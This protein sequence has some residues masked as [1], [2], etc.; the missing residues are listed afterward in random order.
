MSAANGFIATTDH[1]FPRN[2]GE[3]WLDFRTSEADLARLLRR[4]PCS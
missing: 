2:L 3:V 1:R 4:M